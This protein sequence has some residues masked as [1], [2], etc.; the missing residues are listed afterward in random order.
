MIDQVEMLIFRF[1]SILSYFLCPKPTIA[2]KIFF[3][4]FLLFIFGLKHKSKSI[5]FMDLNDTW[6]KK[7]ESLQWIMANF[8]RRITLLRSRHHKYLCHYIRIKINVKTINAIFFC[9]WNRMLK[10]SNKASDKLPCVYGNYR[11]L[12]WTKSSTV[13]L[14]KLM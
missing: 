6:I 9:N 4:S 5:C 14:I 10:K 12:L 1:P 8:I 3:V 13:H 7:C 11:S 2:F